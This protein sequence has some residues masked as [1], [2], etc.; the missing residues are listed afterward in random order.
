MA[1]QQFARFG[2]A[3]KADIVRQSGRY[4]FLL[5]VKALFF[6]RTF[7]PIFTLRA[8]Q[9]ASSLPDPLRPVLLL[10]CRLFHKR[11]QNR[12]GMDLPWDTVIGEGLSIDHGW[13]LVVT[14]EAVIGR[15]VS[16]F[17]GVT[18]GRK[19]RIGEGGCRLSAFPTIGDNV[20][21]GA[22]SIII[23]NVS[24]REGAIVAPGSMVVRDVEA[25]T[26]VG[27]NPM[28]TIRTNAKEDVLHPATV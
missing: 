13:G 5:L 18:I 17:H 4:S 9:W 3:V 15:N 11:F 19:D 16:L 14:R 20:W 7:K 28:K 23:G 12:A 24:I 22:H 2:P 1:R 25:H 21:I 8:C 27:G 6:T 26:V 10:L